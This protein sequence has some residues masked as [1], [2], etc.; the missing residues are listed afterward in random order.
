MNKDLQEKLKAM[1]A[2]GP[3]EEAIKTML[4]SSAKTCVRAQ[5]KLCELEKESR[6]N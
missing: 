2:Q 4:Q 1:S 6:D 5:V 3:I